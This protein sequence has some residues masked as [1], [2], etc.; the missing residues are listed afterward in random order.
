MRIPNGEHATIDIRKIQDYCLNPSHPR[1]RHK[2]GVFRDALNLER[3]APY[4][5]G[6]P[7]SKQ[8]SRAMRP[9][10]RQIAGV[11]TGAWIS[12]SDDMRNKLW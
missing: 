11:V 8:Q 10:L 6:M 7:Y 9:R 12:C 4:G 3:G 1:G 2:A 5:F